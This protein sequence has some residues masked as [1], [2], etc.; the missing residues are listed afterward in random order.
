MFLFQIAI[1]M[2]I[3][4]CWFKS[5]IF[6]SKCCIQPEAIYWD[7]EVEVELEF[8]MTAGRAELSLS[9]FAIL[10]LFIMRQ[11]NDFWRDVV[12]WYLIVFTL[13]TLPK[14]LVT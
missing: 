10:Y 8:G 2:V 11:D 7:T 13:L 12:H 9:S 1:L 3:V 14:L 5:F 4:G 6:Q